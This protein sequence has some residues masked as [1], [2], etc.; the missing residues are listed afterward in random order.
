[1]A[2]FMYQA[3]YTVEGYRGLIKD[4]PSGRKKAI[5]LAVEALGGKVEA[6]YYCFGPDDVV[7]IMEL[8]D[9]VIAASIALNVS[10]SGMVRGRTTALLSVEEVDKALGVKTQYRAP[11]HAG[12]QSGY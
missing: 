12:K 5:E 3:R 11:G 8:P 6:F 4:T 2:K 9:N 7:V 10:A 1:V